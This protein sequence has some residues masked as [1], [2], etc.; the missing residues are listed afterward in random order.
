M[1]VY[2]KNSQT[3][4][5]EPSDLVLYRKPGLTPKL[6]EAWSGLFEVLWKKSL[7]NYEVRALDKRGK[8]KIVHLNNLKKYV[9]RDQVVRCLTVLADE[10]ERYHLPLQESPLYNKEDMK[11]ILRRH[12]S[13]FSDKPGCMDVVKMA[14]DVCD[15]Q[16]I[17][18][19]PYRVPDKMKTQVEE[20]KESFRRRYHRGVYQLLGFTSSA[21][22]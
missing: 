22:L 21:S 17:A 2:N 9:E 11:E 4:S 12:A 20:H 14:I 18:Q 16:P 6:T 3:R 7:V 13:T 5:L 10:A 19:S 1:A 8:G 15:A